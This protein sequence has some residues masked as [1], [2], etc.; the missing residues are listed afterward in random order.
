EGVADDAA[1]LLRVD[2]PAQRRKKTVRGVDASDLEM[3]DAIEGVE[4]FAGFVPAQEP[5]V[6]EKAVKPVADRLVDQERGD[7][8][9]DPAAQAGHD[10]SATDLPPDGGHHV[11]DERSGLPAARASADIVQ[12]V[13]QYL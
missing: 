10:A 4:D 13:A 7:G 1:L 11:L 6:H 2:D 9:V 3:V 12:E 5:V 8:R